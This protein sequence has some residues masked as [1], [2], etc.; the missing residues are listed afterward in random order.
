MIPQDVVIDLPPYAVT[1]YCGAFVYYYSG[2]EMKP[3]TGP[4]IEWTHEW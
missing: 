1:A 4:G 3:E 2:K